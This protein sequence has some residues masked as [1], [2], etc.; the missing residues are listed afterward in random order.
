MNNPKTKLILHLVAQIL[1]QS[2]VLALVPQEYVPVFTAIV[3]VIGVIMG[4]NDQTLGRA[5]GWK[6]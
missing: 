4:Y 6:K 5:G 2:A 1:G 3:A